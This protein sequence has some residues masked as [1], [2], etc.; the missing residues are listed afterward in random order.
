MINRFCSFVSAVW[1]ASASMG[2]GSEGV[3]VRGRGEERQK[4]LFAPVKS[5]F[6][7]KFAT[8]TQKKQESPKPRT[9]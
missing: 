6:A 9:K 7:Q 3:R 4:N 2:G 5:K 8:S 1:S